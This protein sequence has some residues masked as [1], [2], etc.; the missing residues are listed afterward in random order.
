LVDV[1]KVTD[2]KSRIQIRVRIYWSEVWICGSGSAPKFHG[3]ARLVNRIC[4]RKKIRIQ[5]R[6][7]TLNFAVNCHAQIWLKTKK[8]TRCETSGEIKGKI[9]SET[10]G[11]NIGETNR[12]ILLIF[13]PAKIF[14]SGEKMLKLN[15][16]IIKLNGHLCL[17]TNQISEIIRLHDNKSIKTWTVVA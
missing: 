14:T 10:T 16:V 2:E 9:R 8:V 13:S 7:N 11:L 1:S 6:Y 5:Y 4:R 12:I 15:Y 17:N 3:S